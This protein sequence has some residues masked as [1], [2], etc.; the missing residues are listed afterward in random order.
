[1]KPKEV[2]F[3]EH[4]WENYV[5]KYP[6]RFLG[7]GMTLV[8][9]QLS[10]KSGRPD[11][12]FVDEN[13]ILVVVELQ[14][15]ALDRNHFFKCLEYLHDLQ[16]YSKYPVR[17]II[18]C[19]TIDYKRDYLSMWSDK[20]SVDIDTKIISEREV[21]RIITEL[22]SSITLIDKPDKPSYVK[23]II[24]TPQISSEVL[25]KIKDFP[26]R[27]KEVR[28]NRSQ[29]I[30]GNGVG[31]FQQNISRYETGVAVPCIESVIQIVLKENISADWLLLGEG[32][33]RRTS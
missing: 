14:L 7:K 5:A 15:K 28:G 20:F 1:M 6:E 3:S 33:K 9:K 19:N 13:D 25:R 10:L 31:I 24:E 27:L 8:A 12:L 22:D 4:V 29:V 17:V 18:L 26:K 2:E 16:G 23:N 11:L 21:K 30:F 32:D